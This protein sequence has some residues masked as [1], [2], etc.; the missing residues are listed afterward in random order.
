MD[1]KKLDWLK[2]NST[3]VRGAE[4]DTAIYVNKLGYRAKPNQTV[5][6][7]EWHNTI[8]L[9]GCSQTFGSYLPWEHT[10][11][12]MIEQGI[13]GKQ[14]MNLGIP[15]NSVD[16]I[17]KMLIDIRKRV[18]PWAIVVN[19]PDINR[20]YEFHTGKNGMLSYQFDGRDQE[21]HHYFLTDKGLDYHIQLADNMIESARQMWVTHTNWVELTWALTMKDNVYYVKTR[22]RASDDKHWGPGTNKDAAQYVIDQLT[23][24]L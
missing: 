24:F 12:H 14:V 22:D 8:V 13:P 7:M 9:L 2:I 21:L 18:K 11:A 3:K 20:Y 6:P 16:R 5:W 17:W 4:L 15:G 19:W 23:D 10:M 1:A